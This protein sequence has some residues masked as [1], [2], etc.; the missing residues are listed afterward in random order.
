MTR[1]R[2]LDAIVY[3]LAGAD[4]LSGT[5]ATHRLQANLHDKRILFAVLLHRG[6][7]TVLWAPLRTVQAVQAD[8]RALAFPVDLWVQVL[9]LVPVRPVVRQRPAALAIRG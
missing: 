7:V 4:F 3:V 6:S 2:R 8:L 5:R 9:P 1:S